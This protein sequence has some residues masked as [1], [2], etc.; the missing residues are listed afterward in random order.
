MSGRSSERKSSS[1]SISKRAKP[2]MLL[3]FVFTLIT[4]AVLVLTATVTI[5]VVQTT[6][7]GSE[8]PA[9]SFVVYIKSDTYKPGDAIIFSVCGVLVTHRIVEVTPSGF[10]TKGDANSVL[11]PWTV[12]AGSIRGKLLFM[13]PHLGTI[14]FF[15][16][17]PLVFATLMTVAF[18]QV[19]WSSVMSSSKKQQTRKH[20]AGDPSE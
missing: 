12:S 5:A 8:M 7:M 6:S 14:V 11:D 2:L 9:G 4:L 13:V 19:S 15:L 10:S 20:S 18:V 16:R 3:F 17:S 1:T